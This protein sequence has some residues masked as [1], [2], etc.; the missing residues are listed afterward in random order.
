MGLGGGDADPNPEMNVWLSSGAMHLWHPEQKQPSTPWESELD[1][2]MHQQA[3]ELNPVARKRLYDRV[4]EIEQEH[5][6]I[7]CLASPHVLVAARD[8]V[9]NLR[10]AILDHYSLWNAEEIWLAD[11]RR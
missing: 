6:P 11:S 4:Q 3:E 2:L 1:R 7:I 8:R 5:L 10:P 9:K